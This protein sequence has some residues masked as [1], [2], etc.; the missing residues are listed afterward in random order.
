MVVW[1]TDF[2]NG[3]CVILQS[4]GVKDGGDESGRRRTRSSMKPAV[5]APT[6]PPAK[7]ERKTPVKA[8]KK[9][10][11]AKGMVNGQTDCENIT[12]NLF[13]YLTVLIIS[14]I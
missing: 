6:P 2:C 9:E 7:K 4:M 1:K 10:T 12:D 14:F 13:T 3:K 11:P 5:S 8:E